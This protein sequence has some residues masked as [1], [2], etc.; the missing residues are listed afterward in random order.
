MRLFYE[1]EL[2]R[3]SF[4]EMY[5]I[6]IDEKLIENYLTNPTREEIIN[7]ILKYRGAKPTN[8][9]KKYKKNGLVYLQHLFDRKMGDKVFNENKIKVPHKIILYKDLNITKEDNYKIVIPDYIH[10][11]NV[12]LVNSN[13][14]LCGI[15]QLE[16]DLK[17]VPKSKD[18]KV[19]Y[20]SET[21]VS[22][23]D[24]KNAEFIKM[25]KEREAKQGLNVSTGKKPNRFGKPIKKDDETV[26]YSVSK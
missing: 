2:R 8:T 18:T 17:T 1:D 5:Q 23:L 14:Y 4:Y 6:A 22:D 11:G 24:K 13:N 21:V 19:K 16:K 25:K 7:I 26:K 12:F 9:I 15:F 10:K 20:T 3:K